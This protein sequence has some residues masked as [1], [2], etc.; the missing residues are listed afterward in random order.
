M[1]I[2]PS[3]LDTAS[4]TTTSETALTPLTLRDRSK[5]IREPLIIRLFVVVLCV[6]SAMLLSVA[7]S[8]RSVKCNPVN[9]PHQ[10]NVQ[11]QHQV[12]AERRTL[13]SRSSN[14]PSILA[15][16]QRRQQQNNQQVSASNSLSNMQL[17]R[18]IVDPHSTGGGQ[19]S[20]KRF[21]SAFENL[22]QMRL[23]NIMS[24]A[25]EPSSTRNA[26]VGPQVSLPVASN[27]TRPIVSGGD[28]N[29]NG[30]LESFATN[31]V[32]N[33]TVD[34][35]LVLVEPRRNVNSVNG[36]ID[37]SQYEQ[38]DVDRLYGDALLVYLKNFNE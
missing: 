11:Q 20:M 8:I 35:G 24:A 31:D 30:L 3:R 7:I 9:G 23:V 21:R 26:A 27:T 29:N 37:L 32:N 17:K 18:P 1:D 22:P 5:L 4:R 16:R 33:N 38:S 6:T 15:Q 13:H 19:A 2:E 34:S 10:N 28:I 14:K 12:P 36:T 25:S